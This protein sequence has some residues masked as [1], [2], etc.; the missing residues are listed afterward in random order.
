MFL[1]I[2]F[3]DII[4]VKEREMPHFFIN[5]K[6]INGNIVE[7]QED[8][9]HLVKVLRLKTGEKLKL[10]DENE[11]CYET[12]VQEITSSS[13]CTKIEKSYKSTRKL[14]F[15]LYLA[16]VPLRS[17]AQN[18]IIEKAT[19][20]GVKKIYP[21]LSKNCALAKKIVEKKVEKW[22][23]IMIESSKQ[24]ERADIPTC[25][26]PVN[27]ENLLK[28]EKFDKVIAFCERNSDISLKNYL[29]ENKI[30]KGEKILV[31]IGPEGGFTSDEFDF[32]TSNNIPKVT[33]GEMILRAE[34]AVI[35]ALGNIIYEN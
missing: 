1:N 2:E 24:C 32:F 19:E 20:L 5:S 33:L 4:T 10:I 12:V 13:I 7:F 22:G 23:K 17:D 15:D 21:L 31:I 25:T 35:V 26:D 27:F 6:S 8:Y 29:K 11:M 18:L 9:K 16:Q 14:D 30:Q 3:F 28:A 34:T